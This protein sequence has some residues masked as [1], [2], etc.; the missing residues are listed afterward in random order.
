MPSATVDCIQRVHKILVSKYYIIAD[1]MNTS[2]VSTN[3]IEV[4][5]CISLRDK[6]KSCVNEKQIK[7]ITFFPAQFSFSNK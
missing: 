6:L 4:A 3:K 1:V 2:T 5:A 7:K